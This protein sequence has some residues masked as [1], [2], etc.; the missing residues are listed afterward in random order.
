M[1][2]ALYQWFVSI[3]SWILSWFGVSLGQRSVGGAVEEGLD[4]QQEVAVEPPSMFSI[5]TSEPQPMEA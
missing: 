2:D 3:V 5:P 4:A 1:L